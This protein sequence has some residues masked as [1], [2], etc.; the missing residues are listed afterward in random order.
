MIAMLPEIGHFS[1]ILALF[2]AL[3]Q[4][5]LALAG[6]ARGNAAWIALARPAA[7]AQFLLVSIS[8]IALG[9]SF[10]AN[11]FSVLYV[12]QNS[13][14]QLPWFYR[15]AATWGGHEGS[16]LL[17]LLMQTGWA[18]AVSLFSK[19]LPDA[20]VARVLGVL[21]SE[22]HT[23]ELQSRENLVCRLLLEK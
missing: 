10:F 15:I 4:A 19:Q 7:R 18:S 11:D 21:R 3:A 5:S 23:S 16:L 2:V 17:W 13:N 8:F 9:G 1:L 6:A 22:E 14:S 20:M 12:A